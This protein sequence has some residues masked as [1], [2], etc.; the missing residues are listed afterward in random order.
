MITAAVHYP[1]VHGFADVLRDKAIFIALGAYTAVIGAGWVA[2][3]SS[4]Q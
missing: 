3:A 1:A 2:L 4:F